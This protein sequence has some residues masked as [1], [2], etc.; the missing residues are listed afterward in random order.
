[1]VALMWNRKLSKT[2]PGGYAKDGVNARVH[3]H[4][5]SL[6][7]WGTVRQRLRNGLGSLYF[8]GWKRTELSTCAGM[9]CHT[10]GTHGDSVSKATQLETEDRIS[11]LVEQ[12]HNL[13]TRL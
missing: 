12:N 13:H 5:L 10:K 1:M 6:I 7:N 9:K 2:S 8:S 11:L 4:T 3:R